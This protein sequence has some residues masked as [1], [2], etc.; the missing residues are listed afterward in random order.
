MVLILF[1]WQVVSNTTAPQTSAKTNC[2]CGQMCSC[3]F[4]QGE[5][6]CLTGQER[7]MRDIFKGNEC[8]VRNI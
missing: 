3:C 1:K 5:K 6:K 7:N 4:S 8:S 2:V